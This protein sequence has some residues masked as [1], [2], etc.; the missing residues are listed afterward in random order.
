MFGFLEINFQSVRTASVSIFIPYIYPI[1]RL[2]SF[3]TGRLATKPA[4]WLRN[5][6]EIA[7]RALTCTCAN[8]ITVTVD[9]QLP[10]PQLSEPSIIQIQL[11]TL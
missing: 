11:H 4:G 9:R 3:E 2:A 5:C 6:L 10:K 8:N 1:K 7:N